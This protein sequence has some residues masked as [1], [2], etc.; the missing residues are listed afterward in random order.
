MAALPA[1]RRRAFARHLLLPEIG[2]Q[3]QERL[4]AAHFR[5]EEGADPR[6]AEVARDYLERAGVREG[7]DG[8]VVSLPA[9]GALAP[10]LDGGLEHA[11]PAVAGAFAAVETIKAIVG[12][13]R[14]ADGGAVFSVG[15]RG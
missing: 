5:I 1:D 6:A 15:P 13:G 3:G 14:R 2:S 10:E 12:A 7:A 11:A 4:C 9:A 8:W